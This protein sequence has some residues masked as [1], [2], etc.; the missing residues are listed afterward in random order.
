MVHHILH[1][2]G[3]PLLEAVYGLMHLRG[4]SI[5]YTLLYQSSPI[6]IGR[7]EDTRKAIYKS[8]IE[9]W[10]GKGVDGFRVDVVNFYCKDLSF[11]DSEVVLPDEE[12]QPMEPQHCINGPMMHTWLQEQRSIAIDKYGEDIILVGELPGTD[13]DEVLRYIDTNTRELDMVFDMDIFTAGN[14]FD[15]LLHELRPA[16]LTEI[17]TTLAK[18]QGFLNG[19][20]G[21]TTTFLENHDNSRSV[22]RFGPGEGPY[23]TSAAK[24][25]ALLV[26]TLSGTLF[27]YQ[28]QEIGMSGL[29]SEKWKRGDF[30]RSSCDRLSGQDGCQV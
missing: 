28:G 27:V 22:S 19:G 1:V 11:P 10:L 26:V 25:L 16:K 7:H 9:F 21:W 6:S 23:H 14:D 12:F 2:T 20:K 17:K 8:A 15:M 29:P 13:T 4:S 24:M 30:Q 18:T 3:E 5:T